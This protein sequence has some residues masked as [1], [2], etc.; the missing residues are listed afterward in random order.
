MAGGE[1][2]VPVGVVE[3]CDEASVP[4][5]VPDPEPL[6]CVADGE[7][8]LVLGLPEPGLVPVPGLELGELGEL[9]P[10]DGGSEPPLLLGVDAEL[11]GVL[12]LLVGGLLVGGLLGVLLDGGVLGVVGGVLEPPVG[13]LLGGLLG[14][15]P[16]PPWPSP[17]IETI[18]P[19]GSKRTCAVH[20]P[21]G[22]AEESTSTWIEVWPPPASMPE[23]ALRLSQAASGV[24]VQLT[25]PVPEFQRVTSTSAGSFERCDTLMCSCPPASGAEL[26]AVCDG[27]WIGPL[28]GVPLVAPGVPGSEE[29]AAVGSTAATTCAVTLSSAGSPVCTLPATGSAGPAS[30]L[31]L[32]RG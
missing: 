31:E 23:V 8:G 6:G 11:R 5:G 24:A 10:R 27:S 4:L 17:L 25:G 30:E 9:G 12:G 29:A 13:E 2:W 15:L 21:L 20:G 28:T 7:F 1:G 22:P 32:G 3:G 26:V 19:L 14:V 16:P 18:W